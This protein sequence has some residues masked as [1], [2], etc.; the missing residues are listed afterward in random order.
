MTSV[1]LLINNP[2]LIIIVSHKQWNSKLLN[3]D[4]F[5]VIS[6][7]ASVFPV[8]KRGGKNAVMTENSICATNINSLGDANTIVVSVERTLNLSYSKMVSA[9]QSWVNV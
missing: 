2:K 5:N 9:D 6:A 8:L 4:A 1:F 7:K 3:K